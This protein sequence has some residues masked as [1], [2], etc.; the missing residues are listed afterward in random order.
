MKQIFYSLVLLLLCFG[1]ASAQQRVIEGIVKD[2]NG[3]SLVGANVVV[4]GSDHGTV[5][6]A[7]GHFTLVINKGDRNLKVSYLGFQDKN[8]ALAGQDFLDIVLSQGAVGLKE[9]VAIGY[10][11]IKK[12]N[13]T[14]AVAEMKMEK[15]KDRPITDIG[16]ALAGQLAGVRVQSADGGLP[17]STPGITVRGI[18]S[19]N[20]GTGPLYVVDGIPLRGGLSNLNTSDIA[21]IE[22]LKDAASAAIYGSRGSNGVVMI[23]TKQGKEGG[24][25]INLDVQTGL[26]SV[27]KTYEVMNRD[28]WI[29]FAIAERTNTYLLNGGDPS[30]PIQDR[31]GLLAI[32]P[33]WSSNPESFPDNN[34][35]NLIYRRAPF[36]RYHLSVSGGSDKTK[37]YFGAEYLNQ[38]GLMINSGYKRYSLLANVESHLNKRISVG[39][40]LNANIASAT[41][42]DAENLGGPVSRA[43]LLP[44][45]VGIDQNTAAT[46]SNPWVLSALVNPLEWAKQVTDPSNDSRVLS[47]LFAQINI[48]D[49]LTF[50]STVSV[51][52]QNSRDN[53][54]MTNSINRGKGS[55]ADFATGMSVNLLSDNIFTYDNTFGKSHINAIAGFTAQ[56]IDEQS[57]DA[58]ATGFPNDA[59]RTLNAATQILSASSSASGSRLLSYLA[60]AIYSYNDRYLFTASIRRDGSS[61]FGRNNQWGWFPSVSAGWRISDENFMK[62]LSS[63]NNLKLRVS[64]GLTGNNSFPGS[65]DFPSIGA[66][67]QAN[68]VFGSGLGDKQIGLRQSTLSN[69]DLTWEKDKSVDLGLDIAILNN[70]ISASLDF[71]DRL[72]YGLLL[73]VPIPQITGFSNAYQNVGKVDNKGIEFEVNAHALTGKFKWDISA[74]ISHNKNTVKQLGP[75]NTPIPGIVRGTIMSLTKV[76]NPIGAYYLIPILGIF[77]TQDEVDN[78]PV[79]K[80]ENPGDFKYKDSNGDGVINDDDREIVGHNNPD[81]TWGMGNSF[82]YKNLSLSIFVDGVWGNSLLCSSMAGEGQSR[83]NQL[84][85]Y[86]DRWKSPEDPGNGKVPRAAITDN[87]T[88]A[89][90]FWMFN[91]SYW[92]IQNISLGYAF[93]DQIFHKVKGIS[94]VRV[95]LSCENVASFDH[96]YGVPETGAQSN[97]PL[98]P[99]IDGMTTYPLARTFT[100][101]LNLSFK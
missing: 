66:L 21:S 36:Q 18:G 89:S 67:A 70:R 84:S 78:S 79:S 91:A 56:K 94:D 80:R 90:T 58:Q 19:I 53:Y 49:G 59:V 4:L 101:G 8:V 51:E 99:G 57:N 33:K 48:I 81:F 43:V 39:L 32:D 71:Y 22:V 3:N 60:R 34:W 86:L 42:P 26:Q 30:V 92:R 75:E 25:V 54:Y 97:S 14:N 76:G 5:T 100:L 55:T 16:N 68:Y 63:I 47:S 17:G 82:Q 13:L 95:Y 1:I 6:N 15:V 46:G 87:L 29:D 61:K 44:P 73:N 20:G 74:N 72:T 28:Q 38:E 7:S 93:P 9:V 11:N 40:N 83:Q 10:G 37:Y 52:L 88:T 62:G 64:Y 12:A 50:K 65:N 35:A 24:P 85:L 45:I 77:Q 41:N 96:Y 2:E 69:S 27:L 98:A 31:P 23:T